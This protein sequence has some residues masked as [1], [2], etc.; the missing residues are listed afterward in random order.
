M[1][2]FYVNFFLPDS[3]FTV[4]NQSQ[5]VLDRHVRLYHNLVINLKARLEQEACDAEEADNKEQELA[6][7]EESL[8][9]GGG[10]IGDSAVPGLDTISLISDTPPGAQIVWAGG[11]CG[12]LAYESVDELRVAV[13][14][15]QRLH[16]ELQEEAR[17]LTARVEES[18]A[19]GAASRMPGS[20]DDA[21]RDPI[22]SCLVGAAEAWMALSRMTRPGE[23]ERH[24]GAEGDAS[25]L[26]RLPGTAPLHCDGDKDGGSSNSGRRGSL[27]SGRSDRRSTS[28][29]DTGSSKRGRAVS[30]RKAQT[31]GRGERGP[32]G[33][34]LEQSQTSLQQSSSAGW[35]GNGGG[36]LEAAT[37][38][39]ARRRELFYH[40]VD[41]FREYQTRRR[42]QQ[43][44]VGIGGADGEQRLVGGGERVE[45][46]ASVTG[47]TVAAGAEGGGG[48]L[49]PISA[50]CG[51][52]GATASASDFSVSV[53]TL[54]DLGPPDCRDVSTQTVAKVG[55]SG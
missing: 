54:C 15:L 4:A 17:H 37:N 47:S 50:S 28:G 10:G 3:L 24:D 12:A 34:M 2:F 48:E 55:G 20:G 44:A 32:R 9:S 1:V 49:P 14:S 19:A 33:L 11:A 7:L 52:G 23:R 45:G 38:T 26:A 18:K 39:P 30:A 46:S 16:A 22:V 31:P 51:G 5:V 13:E 35:V 21:D 36:T 25:Y 6:E 43:S 27:L 40:L 29:R 8:A 53:R 41:A 42:S